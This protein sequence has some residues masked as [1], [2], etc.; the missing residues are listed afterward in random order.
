MYYVGNFKNP[1]LI[2]WLIEFV[3]ILSIGKHIDTNSSSLITM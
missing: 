2:D 3:G 1:G